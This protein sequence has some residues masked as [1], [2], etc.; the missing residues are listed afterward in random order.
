MGK[1]LLGQV[2]GKEWAEESGR[3]GKLC[4]I[5][6]GCAGRMYGNRKW[7]NM[8][9]KIADCRNYLLY[10][11]REKPSV[12]REVILAIGGYFS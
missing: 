4:E 6:L 3:G 11:N 12:I 5:V 8:W 10:E 1:R 2:T 7:R 9:N